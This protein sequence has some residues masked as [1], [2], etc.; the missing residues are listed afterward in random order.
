M[1]GSVAARAMVRLAVRVPGGD[2]A[3][4]LVYVTGVPGAGKSAVRRELRRRGHI[5]LG[6]D[7][8]GLGAFFDRHGRPVPPADVIDS[9]AWRSRHVWRLVPASLDA[10]RERDTQVVYICGSVAN[11]REVWDHFARV[12]GLV[13][14][15]ATLRYRL[16]T[17]TDNAFG[18]DPDELALVLGW[19]Q[20]YAADAPGWGVVTVDATQALAVV[21]DEI[22]ALTED[23]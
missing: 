5:A 21:V 13:V 20:N 17:R 7:E 10:A 15:E 16:M 3:A 23:I 14:D 4:A 1:T 22:I 18:K 12:I 8:D 6:T 11:D 2:V 19:N 9:A